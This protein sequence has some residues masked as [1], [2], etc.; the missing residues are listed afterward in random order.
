MIVT[1]DLLSLSLLPAAVATHL[2]ATAQDLDNVNCM[3]V[4]ICM[5]GLLTLDGVG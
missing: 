2:K 5:T 1:D 4:H 3:A